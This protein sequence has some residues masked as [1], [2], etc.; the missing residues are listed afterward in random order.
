MGAS[1][2]PC[3]CARG[4]F[5]SQMRDA[6]RTRGRHYV[7]EPLPSEL[8]D[9]A[10]SSADVGL[11]LYDSAKENDRLMGTASGKLCLYLKNGLPVVRR[12]CRAS[13]WVE[14]EGCGVRVRTS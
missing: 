2:L 14:R 10:V 4:G 5:A 13:Q 11:A 3:S 6:G 7:S 9:Y 1:G 8:L 12:G